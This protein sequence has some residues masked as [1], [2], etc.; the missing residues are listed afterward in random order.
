VRIL[1]AVDAPSSH[2]FPLPQ[3]WA[4]RGHPV[5]IVMDRPDG[6]FG[7]A[8]EHLHPGVNLLVLERTGELVDAMTGDRAARS[9]RTLVAAHDVAI[10]GG[11]AARSA[12]AVLGSGGATKPRTVLLAERPDPRTA[13]VRRL[14]RDRWI[15]R[16]LARTDD[17]WSMSAA[18]DRAFIGL[19]KE[20]SCRV[21][22]PIRVPEG[23]CAVAAGR[24]HPGERRHLLVVGRLID[25]KR[26]ELALA[27][28]RE[29]RNEG[30]DVDLTFVGTGP[31]LD[32]LRSASTGLP[33]A[34]LG[35]VDGQEVALRMRTAH[36]LLHPAVYDGWGMVVPEAAAAGLPVVATAGCD[37]ATELA[38]ATEAVIVRSDDPNRLARATAGL[39]DAFTDS[40]DDR[41]HQLVIAARRV[42]GVDTV[43]ERSC[44][45]LGASAVTE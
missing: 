1:L 41:T 14:L 16:C 27:I 39:F 15:Q 36:A 24:W 43:V 18:G 5:T 6:R 38:A 40:P 35:G 32:R 21:P 31:L 4:D 12:R 8:R 29:L 42:C 23:A 25:L 37:A 33:V 22:Y 2:L 3:G 30:V 28:L 34:F 19:G 17:V 20:P 13:G 7:H 45:A 11:Y 10:A 26:P 9:M 44:A